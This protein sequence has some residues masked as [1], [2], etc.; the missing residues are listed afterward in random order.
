MKSDPADHRPSSTPLFHAIP[1][2]TY[3]YRYRVARTDTRAK[4]MQ[5]SMQ[6]TTSSISR[7]EEANSRRPAVS[8]PEPESESEISTSTTTAPLR[9]DDEAAGQNDAPP[10]YPTETTDQILY[11]E[12]VAVLNGSMT[13]LSKQV[14]IEAPQTGAKGR[15]REREARRFAAARIMPS[16]GLV[17]AAKGLG[18]GKRSGSS[19][20]YP[21][22]TAEGYLED[23]RIE[24]REGRVRKS[25]EMLLDG[26]GVDYERKSRERGL[27]PP[28]IFDHAP[29]DADSSSS[30]SNIEIRLV[31]HGKWVSSTE[32]RQILALHPDGE[33][34]QIGRAHV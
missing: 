21:P 17:D 14:G 24:E 28:T 7:P 6:N 31:V 12:T 16:Q 27:S 2:G 9:E 22:L 32:A 5:R 29:L 1:T 30:P 11:R 3:N 25:N 13:L 15:A 8:N 33:S 4:D 23:Q 18:V 19:V 26:C 34:W 10:F 20:S